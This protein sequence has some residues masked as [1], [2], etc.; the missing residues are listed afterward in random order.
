MLRWML[1]P[2]ARL[3]LAGVGVAAALLIP[4][5]GTLALASLQPEVAAEPGWVLVRGDGK[6]IRLADVPTPDLAVRLERG[7]DRNLAAYVVG[8]PNVG[9]DEAWPMPLAPTAPL[10]GFKLKAPAG[11]A[12]PLVPSG[13][14]L[15]HPS[16][17]ADNRSADMLYAKTPALRDR[18]AAKGL[19]VLPADGAH[20]FVES[21]IAQ[22]RSASVALT[23]ASV[24][25]VA[26]IAMAFAE[27]D[28]AEMSRTAAV[29]AALGH[30]GGA[31]ALLVGRVLAVVGIAALAAS[32]VALGLYLFG[33]TFHP[34]PVPWRGLALA[35][36]APTAAA[37]AFGA[38]RSAAGVRRAGGLLRAPSEEISPSRLVP[39]LPPTMQPLLLGTRIL[40]AIA[41]AGLLFMV[42]VGFPLA[43]AGVPQALTGS[44]GE[45]VRTDA[46][47]SILSGRTDARLADVA[48]FD[49]A[50]TEVS[51]EVLVPTMVAGGPALLRGGAWSDLSA[52][53]GLSIVDGEAPQ[54]GQVA[55][56]AGL[57]RRLGVHPGDHILVAGVSRP[58]ARFLEVSGVFVGPDLL[59][60]EGVLTLADAR[61]LA[62]LGPRAATLVRARPDTEEAL[63]AL[64]RSSADL[65]VTSLALSPSQ[66]AAGSI[67]TAQVGVANLGPVPGSRLLFVRV[68]GVAVAQLDARLGGYETDTLQA[69]FVVPR[70]GFTL[71]VN[72]TMQVATAPS[73]MA[74]AAPALQFDN[75]PVLVSASDGSPVPGLEIAMYANASV[76]QDGGP[77]QGVARTDANGTAAFTGIG[78]G[79]HVAAATG[80]D[81]AATAVRVASGANA[82]TGRLAVERVW[83]QPGNPQPGE[84]TAVFAEIVNLGGRQANGSVPL[85]LDGDV[86]GI[87]EVV[88]APG[89]AAVVDAQMAP[90]SGTHTVAA[91]GRQVT[92]QT[93]SP[94]GSAPAGGPGVAVRSDTLSRSAADEALGN[95]RAVLLGLGGTAMASSLALVYLAIARTV[96]HRRG[97]LPTLWSLGMEPERLRRRA[98]VEAAVM[99]LVAALAAAFVGA[100]LFSLAGIVQWPLAFGHSVP[101]PITLTFALQAATAFAAACAGATYLT[102]GRLVDEDHLRRP[103][104]ESR[105][106]LPPESLPALMGEA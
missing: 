56:G 100:L 28:A 2:D 83:L 101:Q 71:A 37:L 44:S 74:L 57:G 25:V 24:P 80:T 38:W 13:A 69:S 17:L 30:P 104:A 68:D 35:L 106:V 63:G 102:L 95:A 40:P 41:L 42:D 31:R 61:D 29:V 105:P 14:T 70:S 18:L 99:G 39:G 84:S 82:T 77:R 48:R 16:R 4:I 7:A 55:V 103:G 64:S 89:E 6:P 8:P 78:P 96:H 19:T 43:V 45:L 97:I 81:H 94:P 51:A 46:T 20:V 76:A 22:V 33:G 58:L 85:M 11:N 36:G 67:A 21:S 53:H 87:G 54:A 62:G 5:A 73:G 27:L 86:I 15:V 47:A 34:N 60:S 91:L 26:L 90:D 93:S 50:I 92:F 59:Q 75:A 32:I 52:F 79:L 12:Q 23:V 9:K 10:T 66:P 88:L 1:R 65:Q 98:S 72:P 3:A 49:P